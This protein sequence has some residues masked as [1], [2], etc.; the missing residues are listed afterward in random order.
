MGNI[1]PRAL[2][3]LDLLRFAAMFCWKTRSPSA[4][5]R[6][7][8]MLSRFSHPSRLTNSHRNSTLTNGFDETN[9]SQVVPYK[10]SRLLR[11]RPGTTWR[12]SLV[13]V[14]KTICL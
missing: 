13:T 5:D 14:P 1:R 2:S 3:S 12:T 7:L 4:F 11:M 9:P 8:D 10:G 6:W